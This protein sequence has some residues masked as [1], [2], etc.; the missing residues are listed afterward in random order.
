MAARCTTPRMHRSSF[1]PSLFSAIRWVKTLCLDHCHETGAFRGWVCS[2]CNTGAGIADSIERLEKRIAFLEVHNEK[3]RRIALIN[4]VHIVSQLR[5]MLKYAHSRFA[6][7]NLLAKAVHPPIAL[8]EPDTKRSYR[9]GSG[10]PAGTLHAERSNKAHHP[11]LP[12][13]HAG[14]LLGIDHRCVRHAIR[15]SAAG[16]SKRSRGRNSI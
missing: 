16:A 14:S 10:K 6:D 3:M 12:S 15:S 9:Y 11:I 4:E 13:R 2:P 7:A 8:S 5:C 1:V